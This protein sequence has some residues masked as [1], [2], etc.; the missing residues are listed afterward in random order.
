MKT[1]IKILTSLGCG[2]AVFALC[3]LVHN[4]LGTHGGSRGMEDLSKYLLMVLLALATFVVVLVLQF[5]KAT[6][7][8]IIIVTL[9]PIVLWSTVT[10]ANHIKIEIRHYMY[11]KRHS[12]DNPWKT[13]DTEKLLTR[14]QAGENIDKTNKKGQTLLH[15]AADIGDLDL[16]KFAVENGADISK[17]DWKD[18]SPTYYAANNIYRSPS[19][20]TLLE[21]LAENGADIM[22][23]EAS[24]GEPLILYAA[25]H[26]DAA[27]VSMLI[28]HG[29]SVHTARGY[30]ALFDVKSAEIAQVL[31][32]AGADVNAKSIYERIPTPVF[33][34]CDDDDLDILKL[35]IEAGAD[36]EVRDGE[37][38]TPLL[39]AVRYDNEAAILLMDAG[40][41]IHVRNN[42]GYTPLLLA[43]YHAVVAES[44]QSVTD[45]GDTLRAERRAVEDVELL[46]TLVERGAD[47]TATDSEGK[48]AYDI[49]LK[50]GIKEEEIAFLKV[51]E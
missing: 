31:I 15:Y 23:N 48:T 43:A 25:K 40:A 16:T 44:I 21:Y 51:S 20:W 7:K 38:N 49:A 42:E 11:W 34:Y 10:L 30:T 6:M 27:T 46:Q 33:E 9:C 4:W 1:F 3:A 36:L 35:L 39:K 8:T 24:G 22:E 12:V 2:I 50:G 19:N 18:N 26:E 29:I 28:K 47:K 17:K 37:G 45:D 5:N 14:L 13:T 41:D 32:D